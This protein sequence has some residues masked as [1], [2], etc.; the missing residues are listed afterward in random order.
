[1]GIHVNIIN[2]RMNQD[3]LLSRKKIREEYYILRFHELTIPDTLESGSARNVSGNPIR[4]RPIAY[5]TNT[6]SDWSYLG[7]KER[8]TRGSTCCST[9][10]GWGDISG[11]DIDDVL[12]TYLSLQV[13]NVHTEPLDSEYRRLM[14]EIVKWT[15]TALCGLPSYRTGSC[16]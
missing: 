12:S 6:L 1:M 5:L 14:Q 15:I 7:P 13:E 11:Q 2:C 10:C 3:W 8:S 9:R 16:C 4:T